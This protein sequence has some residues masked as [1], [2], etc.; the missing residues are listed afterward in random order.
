MHWKRFI[1]A[2]QLDR[3]SRDGII[4]CSS[5]AD[6]KKCIMIKRRTPHSALACQFESLEN[7]T[8]LSASG[9][10]FTA[11]KKTATPATAIQLKFS[12]HVI[13]LG[14]SL[15]LTVRAIASKGGSVPTGTVE[16]LSN[17]TPI[18]TLNGTLDL[19]LSSSGT[20]SYTF[21]AGSLQ[22]AGGTFFLSAKYLGD[23]THPTGTSA[24][25]PLYVITPPFRKIGKAGL[26]FSTV[27]IGKGSKTAATGETV[28]VAYTGLLASNGTIFDYDTGH[29][30][31]STPYLQFTVEASPE[32]VITGFDEGV[33]GMKVG[34]T[35]DIYVPSALGYGV[36][37]SYPNI[38]SN[39]ALIFF[40]TLLKIM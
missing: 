11:A 22:F 39:A 18:T 34:E 26:E 35:R 40:V 19:T 12:R 20:A 16:L 5:G 21:A 30:A 9:D 23:T 2:P 3:K 17:N 28:Q 1:E 38:P 7:R 27:Q 10:V 14:Q 4:R 15:T 24:V 33:M 32:Q 36:D 8:L 25:E 13:R 31:G 6:G 37:G 29:G